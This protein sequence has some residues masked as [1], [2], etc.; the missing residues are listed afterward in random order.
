MRVLDQR[1]ATLLS[2]I[3]PDAVPL[4]DAFGF[5]DLQLKSTLG[6][7]DG[8]VYEAI[9]NEAKKNPLNGSGPMVG[10]DKLSTVLDLDFL[11]E[12][13]KVQRAIPSKAATVAAKL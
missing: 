7:F 10:W 9:Y 3:R 8:N 13:A 5:L 4:V 6:R 11:D 12:T 2:E 1:I